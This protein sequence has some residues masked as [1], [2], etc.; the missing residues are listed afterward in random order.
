MAIH[1]IDIGILTD[2]TELLS[3]TDIAIVEVDRQLVIVDLLSADV[4]L[5]HDAGLVDLER[6]CGRDRS[7]AQ[8]ARDQSLASDTALEEIREFHGW[9]PSGRMQ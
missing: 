2:R 7:D 1:R 5:R 3:G 9:P 6:K 4:P 8:R